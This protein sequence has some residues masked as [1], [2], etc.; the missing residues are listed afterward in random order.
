MGEI[1]KDQATLQ[2]PWRK[3]VKLGIAV[4]IGVVIWCL[5]AP[6]EVS[7]EAWQLLAIFV[8]TIAGIMLAPLPMGA[9]AIFG[10]A[11]TTL[12]GTLSI[13]DA[14]SGFGNSVLW[15]VLMA[16]FIA[17]GFIKTGLGTRI[18]YLFMAA[19]GRRTLGLGYGMVATDLVLA[20]AIPSITARS[21]AVIYPIVRSTAEA[22]GSR[23]R[24]GTAQK[25]GAFLTL[26]SFQGTLV[27]SA[28]FLTAMAANPL[29]AQLA[30]DQGIEITWARWAWAAVVPG[31]ISLLV[32]PLVLY[33]LYRPQITETPEA[34]EM[35]KRRLAEM[36]RMKRSE[37][38]MLGTF[39]LL[40][41]LWI[42]G[43]ALHVHSTTAALVGLSVLLA[44]RVLTW[45]DVLTEKGAWDTFIWLSALVMMASSL[46]EL[47]LIP[48]FSASVGGLLPDVGWLPAFLV[49]SLIYFY[50]HYFF[51]SLTAH[52]SSMYAAFLAVALAVGTPPLLAAL[53]LGFFSNLFASTTH[54]GC[55]PAPVLFGAGYVPLARWW[56]LGAVISVVNIVIWLGLGGCWWKII[57]LW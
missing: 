18:A 7:A 53:V 42:F 30:G 19:I 11:A 9:I 37:W 57:G 45:E 10:I 34:A 13:Q 12:T 49:L 6:A 2:S 32:V 5:P 28:M 39:L 15:L 23:P 16:F 52:I 41:V 51:A 31:L 25:I 4:A 46:N 43:R 48:W 44:T 27:T 8:A 22:Y 3:G 54:Y 20:P 35:A 33:K 47:G 26:T 1:Q 36:G 40:L 55:G 29:A 38:I 21:G 50:S 24:D 56:K 14:L 17:R